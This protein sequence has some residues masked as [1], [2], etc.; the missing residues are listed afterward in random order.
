MAIDCYGATALTPLSLRDDLEAHLAKVRARNWR[1][2]NGH[3]KDLVGDTVDTGSAKSDVRMRFYDKRAERRAKD[4]PA[5]VR[6]EMQLRRAYARAAIE[7]CANTN[8]GS[9]IAGTLDHYLTW[10][11]PEY[12]LAL[13]GDLEV[14]AEVRRKEANRRKWLK[15]QAARA[16]AAEITSDNAFRA[17]FDLMVDYWIEQ[18][19]KGLTNL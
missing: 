15:G 10:D 11:N 3:A 8:A 14:P 9:V 18:L 17:E 5:W 12:A 16:L 4:G 13:A 7:G 6:F 1:Y 19:T 2:V